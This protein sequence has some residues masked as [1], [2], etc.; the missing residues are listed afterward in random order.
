VGHSDAAGQLSIALPVETL[1]LN[2]EN[3]FLNDLEPQSGQASGVS[4]LFLT[5]FSKTCPQAS[6]RYSYMGIGNELHFY[7]E[8]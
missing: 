7:C 3:S 1:G 5:S 8:P 4:W 6:Q 2:E